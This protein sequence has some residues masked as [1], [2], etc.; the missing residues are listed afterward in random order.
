MTPI[1]ARLIES[2]GWR[3]ALN[4]TGAG[5]CAAILLAVLFLVRGKP[6]SSDLQGFDEFEIKLLQSGPD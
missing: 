4:M 6:K 3:T 2:Y 5:V 1:V